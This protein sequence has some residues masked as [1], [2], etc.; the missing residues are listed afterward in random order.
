M[1]QNSMKQFE[2]LIATGER[3]QLEFK[4]SIELFQSE[5]LIQFDKLEHR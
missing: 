1:L 5:R 2:Q 3:Y 4:E